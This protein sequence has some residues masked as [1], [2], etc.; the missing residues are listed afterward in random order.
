[1]LFGIPLGHG[2]SSMNTAI[3]YL[4]NANLIADFD[5]DKSSVRRKFCEALLQF[6]LKVQLQLPLIER[7]PLTILAVPCVKPW[8]C[9]SDKMSL[10]IADL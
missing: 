2:Q 10:M 1:M 9:E 7:P 6:D 5:G 8:P 4:Q 3:L